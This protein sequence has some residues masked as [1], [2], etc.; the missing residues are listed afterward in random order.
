MSEA[1]RAG[2]AAQVKSIS[3]EKERALSKDDRFRIER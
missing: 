1:E 2:I 3:R